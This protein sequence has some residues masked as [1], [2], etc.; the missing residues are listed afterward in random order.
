MYATAAVRANGAT[1]PAASSPI[2][3]PAKS[4]SIFRTIVLTVGLIALAGGAFFV[5]RMTIG[6]PGGWW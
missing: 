3:P 6:Q 1:L 5:W 4:S 2:Q